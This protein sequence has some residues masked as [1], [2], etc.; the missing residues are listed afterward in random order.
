[1]LFWDSFKSLIVVGRGSQ[2]MTTHPLCNVAFTNSIIFHN[3]L[4]L[5][6]TPGKRSLTGG[7]ET[8]TSEVRLRHHPLRPLPIGRGVTSV[9]SSSVIM[10]DPLAATAAISTLV[11]RAFTLSKEVYTRTNEIINAP[12]HIQAITGD[13][14]D[15]YSI[16]G[17]LKMYLDEESD[18]SV[19]LIHSAGRT[20]LEKA[21]N[22][23]LLVFDRINVLVGSYKARGGA[24]IS[25]W[26]KMKYSFKIAETEALR[27]ELAAHKLSLNIAISLVNL[28]AKLTTPSKASM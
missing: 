10:A 3:I 18:L 2:L 12:Q 6:L 27:S 14:E 13:L 8:C 1:M 17:T 5:L 11:I 20:N 21:L 28:Y 9:Y 7:Y 4:L 15:F 22:N 24:S 19:G 26:R 23:C 25:G 16:L